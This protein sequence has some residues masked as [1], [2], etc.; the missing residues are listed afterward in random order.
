MTEY[1]NISRA[2]KVAEP[3]LQQQDQEPWKQ[4]PFELKKIKERQKKLEDA[5]HAVF[6]LGVYTQ[7]RPD[8]E[9]TFDGEARKIIE[10]FVRTGINEIDIKEESQKHKLGLYQHVKEA[11][12]LLAN[13]LKISKRREEELEAAL[14]KIF[15][16]NLYTQ[17]RPDVEASCDGEVKKIID[18]F[19]SY[20]INET[21]ICYEKN[22]VTYRTT[23]SCLRN[24]D[25]SKISIPKT[26][27]EPRRL[28]FL[29]T[30]GNS[31]NLKTN[32]D[33]D[34]AI[35]H[36]L[37]HY[38]SNSICTW[39][40]K[41]GC[42]NLRYS[43]SKENGAISNIDEIE[44]MHHNN[45]CFNATTK[46]SLQADYTFIILRN[47]FRRL[48]S[49][50]LD[51]LCHP[52]E[53]QSERSYQHAQEVF[54]FSENHS[55]LD[56]INYIW[57]NPNSIY[58][59]E[60]TRPQCDFLLY[61]QYDD[62]F[63]LE[64]SEEANQRIY[65]RTGIRIDDVRDRNSIFTSKGREYTQEITSTTQAIK[66]RN[67]LEKNK[68][69]VIEN[70]YSNEMIK[71]VASLYLQDILLYCNEINSNITELDYWVQRAISEE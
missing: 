11:A 27:P 24:I 2:F 42:S 37:C 32:Q 56:F 30:K 3:D 52:Q 60:H 23:E 39:I 5:L 57:E 25:F 66:I 68:I 12:S 16:I 70:M 36:T 31:S 1:T 69:P 34:F 49:F 33:H 22:K 10:Y 64:R 29:R 51:K 55:F 65:E 7:A 43:V 21:D 4:L 61:R 18:H 59:D 26:R 71:K 54:R 38:K 63:A 9:E 58:N 40:P 13:E 14:Q 46:E 17:V 45:D 6:P 19:I 67:S 28:S 62:Y 50:F 44:W 41:N 35:K 53:E 47:P 20:G 15:P 48:L 8:V